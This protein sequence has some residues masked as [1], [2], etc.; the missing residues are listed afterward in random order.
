MNKELPQKNDRVAIGISISESDDHKMEKNGFTEIHLTD[1]FVEFC[2]YLIA[3]GKNIIYG[4]DLRKFGYTQILIDLFRQYRDTVSEEHPI[5]NRIINYLS[6]PYYQQL[7][8][9]KEKDLRFIADFV[10]INPPNNPKIDLEKKVDFSNVLNMEQDEKEALNASLTHMR[11]VMIEACDFRIQM[12]GK[13]HGYHG[14]APG[15]IEEAYTAIQKDVPMFL[16][17]MFGGATGVIIERLPESCKRE[18][19]KDREDRSISKPK[20]NP[21]DIT[22]ES[23]LSYISKVI[24]TPCKLNNGLNCVENKT[25]FDSDD[26]DLVLALILKGIQSKGKVPK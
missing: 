15:I 14:I 23:M 25:L 7:S 21:K 26:F 2:R 18:C 10:K 22:P 4:G 1:F 5:S 20:Q 12:G 11:C 17:G 16:V 9:K 8:K 24:S 6:W 19:P 3:S 13:M